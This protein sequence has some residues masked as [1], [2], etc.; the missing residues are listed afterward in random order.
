MI[1]YVHAYELLS[2]A[3]TKTFS[4]ILSLNLVLLKILLVFAQLV[5]LS[6][7]LK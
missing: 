2:E 7:G 1:K 3:R 4:L 5:L 6:S